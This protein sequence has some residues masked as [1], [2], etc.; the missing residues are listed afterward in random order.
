VRASDGVDVARLGDVDPRPDDVVERG[1]RL[2]KRPLDDPMQTFACSY[3]PP[4][5]SA[6]SG[7]IGAVPATQ[8]WLPTRT[9]R[10]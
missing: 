1:A 2:R 9:A 3:A 5:G 7:M 8:T 4:G 6:S 10:E